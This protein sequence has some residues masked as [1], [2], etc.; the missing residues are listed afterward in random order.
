MGIMRV[1]R[2]IEGCPWDI[3]QTHESIRQSLIEEAYEVVDAIDS[4]DVDNLCEELGDLLL[5][6]IFH[7]QIAY[8][9]GEFNPIDITSSLA[10]KLILR[11]P[12]VFS[13]KYVENSTEVVYNWNKIKYANRDITTLTG[14]LKDLP[15]L[16]ALMLSFKVQDKAADIGFDWDDIQGPIDKVKEEFHEVMEAMDLYGKEDERVE[17]EVGDLLFAVVNLSRFLSVNPEV[18]LNRTIKKFINRLEI[19]EVKSEEMGKKL[20]DLN[21]QELDQLWNMAK[22]L[23]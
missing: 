22:E 18:A 6:V 17:G 14:I 20:D 1:L 3:E 19:M 13:Q 21:L 16:P 10:N 9:E 8:E 4:K 23:E 2:G 5:Q 11:H 12:H 15:R 7:S